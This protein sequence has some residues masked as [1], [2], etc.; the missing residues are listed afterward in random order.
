MSDSFESENFLSKIRSREPQAFE[1]LVQA[2]TD[3][4]YK[5]CL[6]LGFKPIE[7]E[8]VTQNTWLTFF[9]IAPKF[10]GRSKVRTFL[11]GILYNKA[12]EY[13]KKGRKEDPNFDIEAVMD[14][15]FDQAGHWISDPIDPE[16]FHSSSQTM[17]LINDCLERLPLNQKMAF[18][19]K[20][21]QEELTEDICKILE[22][23]TTNLGVLLF[24]ARNQLR[25]CIERKS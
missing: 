1:S 4:L 18:S 13:R 21:I 12:S 17:S 6:G 10:E 24:R 19:L 16:K 8:D 3:E 25:E 23:T 2:Y 14:Q 20:E 22:I 11:L 15:H 7:A 5:A 9:D